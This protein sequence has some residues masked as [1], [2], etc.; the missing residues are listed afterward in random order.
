MKNPEFAA[1]LARSSKDIKAFV[2]LSEVKGLPEGQ[3]VNYTLE[4]VTYPGVIS[5]HPKWQAEKYSQL[6]VVEALTIAP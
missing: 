1:V 6:D 4:G 5:F 3:R 2:K